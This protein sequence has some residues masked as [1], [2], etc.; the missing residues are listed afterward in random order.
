M[1]GGSGAGD[2]ASPVSAES[3]DGFSPTRPAVAA[4][5]RNARLF[6]CIVG[7]NFMLV[8]AGESGCVRFL[9]QLRVHA[10]ELVDEG[11]LLMQ[12]DSSLECATRQRC[13]PTYAIHP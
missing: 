1:G 11:R 5:P 9:L 8:H 13:E 10:R 3:S 6:V 7:S 12:V 4:I 2:L